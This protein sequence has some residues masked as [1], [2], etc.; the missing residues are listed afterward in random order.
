METRYL[1]AWI[2][3]RADRVVR[4]GLRDNLAGKAVSVPSVL[5]K[6]TVAA[7]KVLPDRLLGGPARRARST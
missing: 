5:Y 3:L 7:S 1:P 2:W 6:A 4:D